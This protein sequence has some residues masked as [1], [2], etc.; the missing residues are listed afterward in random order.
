MTRAAFFCY[1]IQSRKMKHYIWILSIALMVT[2]CGQSYEQQKRLSRAQR[3]KLMAQDSAAFK[4]AV[5]PTLDCL[6]LY[7]AEHYG[8]FGNMGADVRLKAYTAQMDCDT[9]LERGRVE[10]AVTDIVR[11][12]RMKQQGCDLTY[13]TA[14]DAYWLLVSNRNARVNALKQLKDKMVAMARFS[15]TDLLSDYA[16]D[17]VRIDH[18]NL[19]KVQINDV[20]VRLDMIVNNEIDA[21]WLAEPQATA[22]TTLKHK[23]I[24][25]SRTTGL[26]LGAMAY[27]T[28][29][30]AGAER[31]KQLEIVGKAYNMAVDSIN[32]HGV[33]FYSELV[34]QK[35]KVKTAVA[36]TI[37][38]KI[39]FSHTHQPRQADIDK[40]EKWLKNNR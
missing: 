12:Q 31:E 26:R 32:K 34:A 38:R 11:A 4:V 22:A 9:A 37:G 2:A 24:M 36:K 28:N 14:T 1:D 40:A 20:N 17:S 27:R 7:V 10:M 18:K 13:F 33:D 30:V 25:D 35:C 19:F 5:M 15:A 8:L 6:P 21:M 39:T 29:D 23:V 3:A 16:A